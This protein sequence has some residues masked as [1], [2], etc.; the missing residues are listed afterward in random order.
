MRHGITRWLLAGT[1]VVADTALRL[2]GDH[3]LWT[4]PVYVVVI[5]AAVLLV[6]RR[7]ML[8]FVAGLVVAAVSVGGFALLLFSSY[9][10]G[11]A[12][13]SRRDTAVAAGG[14]LGFAGLQLA[15]FIGTW[16][17]GLSFAVV[18][19]VLPLIVGRYLAQH[20]RTVE[21]QRR[22]HDLL[23]ERERLRERLRIARDM[24]DSLGHRLSLVS[25]QAA[26]MEVN[27]PDPVRRKEIQKLAEAARAAMDEVYDLVSALRRPDGPPAPTVDAIAELVRGRARLLT[28][29][30]PR[31]LPPAVGEAAYRVVQEGLTNAAKHAPGAPVTVSLEWEPDALIVTVLNAAAEVGAEGFG[32]PGLAERVETVGGFLDHRIVDGRFRLVAMLP[33]PQP[34]RISPVKTV[35]IGAATAVLLFLL[36]M[37]MLLGAR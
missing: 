5:A 24:H 28:T 11:K 12:L 31:E 33:E 1:V 34:E 21:Q 27:E 17:Q 6:M 14:L 4:L 19:T 18:F 35:L 23:A 26:A 10:A 2:G 16:K 7:P 32:L 15:T 37:G 29:G 20:E 22:Q 3:A 13:V 9:A 30:P 36:P 8:G 25:I